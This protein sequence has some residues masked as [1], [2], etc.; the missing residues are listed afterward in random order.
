MAYRSDASTG[1]GDKRV[2]VFIVPGVSLMD[3][4]SELR[5]LATELEQAA[6]G[7]A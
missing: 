3:P 7:L 4:A 1:T 6:P 5:R 2:V